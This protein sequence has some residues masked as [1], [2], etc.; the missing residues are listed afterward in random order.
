MRNPLLNFEVILTKICGVLCFRIG[1]AE[2]ATKLFT[3]QQG[4]EVLVY[5]TTTV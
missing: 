3:I 4:Y 1:A 5:S 2:E